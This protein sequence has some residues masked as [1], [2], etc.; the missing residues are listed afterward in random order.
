MRVFQNPRHFRAQAFRIEDAQP[1]QG[2]IRPRVGLKTLETR[3]TL[4]SCQKSNH[5]SLVVQPIA[6]SSDKISQSLSNDWFALEKYLVRISVAT[7]TSPRSVAAVGSVARY[8]PWLRLIID[9]DRFLPRPFQLTV[10]CHP[11]L[12][13]PNR[14]R[15]H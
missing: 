1:L 6:K 12:N 4:C 3:K 5:D 9:R 10:H 15:S 2:N 11:Y 13:L 14:H 7:P 8:T